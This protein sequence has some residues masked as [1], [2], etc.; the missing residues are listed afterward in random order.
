MQSPPQKHSKE[1]EEIL[2]K[3]IIDRTVDHA[4]PAI[5]AE[6]SAILEKLKMELVI[7]Q[8]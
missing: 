2:N 1:F 3:Q 7:A 6:I 5:F 4:K 8:G